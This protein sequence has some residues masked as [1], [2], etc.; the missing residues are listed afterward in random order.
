MQSLKVAGYTPQSRAGEKVK[1]DQRKAWPVIPSNA[2]W[3]FSYYPATPP[4]ELSARPL[5][6]SNSLND[7]FNV[8][9]YPPLTHSNPCENTPCHSQKIHWDITYPFTREHQCQIRLASF[10]HDEYHRGDLML[11]PVYTCSDV[12]H[13]RD[14]IQS[15]HGQALFH[16]VSTMSQFNDP[17][18]RATKLKT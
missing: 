12:K 18:L 1:A 3:F 5:L 15:P 11:I 4:L 16:S 2:T 8:P 10:V 7:S 9:T 14:Y 13:R 17:S 6:H